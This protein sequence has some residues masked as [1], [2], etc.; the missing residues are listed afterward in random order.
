MS[1]NERFSSVQFIGY[2]GI[3]EKYRIDS[4][5][6]VRRVNQKTAN[7]EIFISVTLHYSFV[8]RAYDIFARQTLCRQGARTNDTESIAYCGDRRVVVNICDR[9]STRP[10]NVQ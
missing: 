9:E 5:H 6:T 1:I 10:I 8:P 2:I 3:S 7:H 4:F